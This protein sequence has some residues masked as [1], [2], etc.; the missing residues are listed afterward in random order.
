VA[1]LDYL[2]RQGIVHESVKTSNCLVCSGGVVKLSDFGAIAQLV[3]M[4]TTNGGGD[5]AY[6]SDGSECGTTTPTSSLSTP[7]PPSSLPPA[8]PA[9]PGAFSSFV[10][11]PLSRPSPGAGF[12]GSVFDPVPCTVSA[13]RLVDEKPAAPA[14][15]A[16]KL[17]RRDEGKRGKG[18]EAAAPCARALALEGSGARNVYAAPEV[19]R[20]EG[21][22]RQADI[23][24]LGCLVLEMGTLTTILGTRCEDGVNASDVLQIAQIRHPPTIPDTVPPDAADFLRYCLAPEPRERARAHRL[25]CHKFLDTKSILPASSGRDFDPAAKP[26]GVASHR[27]PGAALATRSLPQSLSED[28]DGVQGGSLKRPSSLDGALETPAPGSMSGQSEGGADSLRWPTENA[29]VVGGSA[30]GAHG[31]SD[32]ASAGESQLGH[33]GGFRPPVLA[34]EDSIPDLEFLSFF[35]VGRLDMSSV[36]DE[37]ATR[38]L[39][40][41]GRV[42]PDILRW[43]GA[44]LDDS[45]MEVAYA[46]FFWASTAI[47]PGALWAAAAQLLV[48]SRILMCDHAVGGDEKWKLRRGIEA[49]LCVGNLLARTIPLVIGPRVST[50]EEF[51]PDP[52]GRWRSRWRIPVALVPTALSLAWCVGAPWF[53]AGDSAVQMVMGVGMVGFVGAGA[54]VFVS[55]TGIFSGAL[56]LSCIWELSSRTAPPDASSQRN[57][58]TETARTAPPPPLS[59]EEVQAYSVAMLFVWFMVVYVLADSRRQQR[60]RFR[61][62]Y[63]QERIG[64][65]REERR[66]KRTKTD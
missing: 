65:E 19:L 49:S 41:E 43:E 26:A 6:S 25:A 27:R 7:T 52:S 17:C 55:L 63:M 2:H 21:H 48:L 13:G 51:L 38:R 62:K 23:W 29:C 32:P 47:L 10:P 64:A 20:H 24:S 28:M 61:R 3:P 37:P 12:G 22:G 14:G 44:F 39:D 33:P 16:A 46:S 50:P 8:I 53:F 18:G 11:A 42:L 31:T 54:F 58:M 45:K 40:W 36:D 59:V 1:G 66:I 5:A 57:T 30:A 4:S 56:V 35:E 9:G 60:E 34:R 15:A